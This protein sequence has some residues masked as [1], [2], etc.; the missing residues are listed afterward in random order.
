MLGRAGDVRPEGPLLIVVAGLHGN[1]PAGVQAFQ[2]VLDK[3][4]SRSAHALPG[5]APTL[6]GQLVGISGNRQALAYGMR[7]IDRDLN[8]AWSAERIA[9]VRAGELGQAAE[10][11]EQRDLLAC[12]DDVIGAHDGPV[13]VLDL[14]T[15][16]GSG[17]AFTTTAD[18][19]A[20]R[21]LAVQLQVPLV[22]GL[23]ELL[24]GTLHDYLDTQGCNA[25]VFEAGQHDDP[26]S[27]E[28]AEAAIWLMLAA[29]GVLASGRDRQVS[30]AR[31]RLKREARDRPAVVEMRYRH[32]VAPD[33]DFEMAPGFGNFDRI[34]RGQPLAHDRDGQVRAPTRGR[35]L[36]PLY[37]AQGEDGYF[38]VREFRPFWLA[39]SAV[40]RER[41]VD[42]WVHRLPGIRVSDH[43]PDMLV[44]NRRV[45]RWYALQ[46]LHLL[47]YRRHR[48]EGDTLV[49][50]RRPQSRGEARP[51]T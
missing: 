29:T 17:G 31:A 13:H 6:A 19:L 51:T 10:D 4:A 42:R 27:I 3:L 8:R 5:A 49:V 43:R 18:S 9:A 2:R 32:P 12:L 39:V 30:V 7:F 28:R 34:K 40:L 14:H 45:A 15:T 1:E 47:G 50:T 21:A 37:Q 24:E 11:V 22:L 36:M 16:S 44:V 25:V 33:D 48:A 23:E 35:I 46:L 38:I 20:N 41:G 26:A